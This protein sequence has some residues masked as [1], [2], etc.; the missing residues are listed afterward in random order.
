LTLLG[1]PKLP[2]LAPVVA[3]ISPTGGPAAG[4]TQITIT[5]PPGVIFSPDS[6]VDFGITPAKS[7]AV[8]TGGA[9][10]TAVSPA[11][12]G[13]VDVRVTNMF[14]T[15]PAVPTVPNLTLTDYSDQFTYN[16]P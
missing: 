6:K 12:V 3:S 4:G 15:S 9:S 2:A 1:A 7:Q 8:A 14:G 5:P 11:G 13:T 16:A 10:M